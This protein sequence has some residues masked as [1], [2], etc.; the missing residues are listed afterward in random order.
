[1]RSHRR[2]Y[3]ALLACAAALIAAVGFAEPAAVV[4]QMAGK[5][6]L[7]RAGKTVPIAV[8]TPLE[9]GDRVVVPGGSKAVLMYR[10]GKIE[11]ATAPVTIAARE[12]E[13]VGN[14]YRQTMQTIAQVATTDAARQ[15]NRQGMIR[16]VPGEPTPIA[17]RNGIRVLDVRPTFS[18]FAVPG[19]GSYMI[20]LRRTDVAG[21]RPVRFQAGMDTVWSYPTTAPPLI[22]GATY[23]W[24]VAAGAAGR[25]A[26]EN[27]FRVVDGET[28]ARVQGMLD[29]L[30]A[31]GVDPSAD[32]LFVTAL[33]YRD[34][35]LYYEAH[36]A[37]TGLAAAGGTGRTVYL[38]HGEVLDRIGDLEAA[39]RAFRAADASGG[40]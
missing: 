4:I 11:T 38:L 34:T 31:A 18:W 40:E 7:Q 3:L 10:T 16:P 35:G 1:M 12:S 27:T 2:S 13:Q 15:P 21:S 26:Q 14:L 8:G 9:A 23:H 29:D 19:A 28:L 22:P 5:V 36:R 33:W 20:Q 25:P 32:G 6:E 17:P 37:L 30:T 39:S 24:T